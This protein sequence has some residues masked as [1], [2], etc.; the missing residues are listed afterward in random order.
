MSIC[1]KLLGQQATIT[2]EQAQQIS[3]LLKTAWLVTLEAQEW[4]RFCQIS[5]KWSISFICLIFV[6]A[7]DAISTSPK[8]G[9]DFLPSQGHLY[10]RKH[11]TI[12]QTRSVS[13]QPWSHMFLAQCLAAAIL[14]LQKTL[15]ELQ[16]E[17][18]G[19]T[20]IPTRTHCRS[21]AGLDLQ[22]GWAGQQDLVLTRQISPFEDVLFYEPSAW[23]RKT[24]RT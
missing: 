22:Q 21:S 9:Q 6:A 5:D 11:R 8:R 7:F 4:C 3:S 2:I 18:D 1:W 13:A 20:R 14:H 16:L 12:T 15:Q 23:S 17:Q 10:I 24:I 19:N